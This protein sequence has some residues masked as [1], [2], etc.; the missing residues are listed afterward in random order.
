MASEYLLSKYKDIQPREPYQ[1]TWEERRRNWFHYHKWHLL[2]GVG[3]LAFLVYFLWTVLGIGVVKP[4][5]QA[6]YVGAVPLP[7]ETVILLEETLASLTDD[8]NQDGKNVA[9][10]VQYVNPGGLE[11]TYAQRVKLMA[12]IQSCKSAV[13][14]LEDPE[15]F[16]R[17]YHILCKLD[18]SLPEVGD[19]SVTESCLAYCPALEGLDLPDLFLAR[20]GYWVANE[21]ETACIAL[22]TRLA[23]DG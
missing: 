22:W 1:P 23:G 21:T 2:V 17:E 14:L 5:V 9:K 13:F 16:Q 4:D 11:D 10:V 20:R 18:G 7:D 19:D 3:G 6:A 15:G 12:D 8:W